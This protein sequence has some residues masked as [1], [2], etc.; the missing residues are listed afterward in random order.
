MNDELRSRHSATEVKSTDIFL[1]LF[2]AIILTTKYQSMAAF[3]N[4][5][6]KEHDLNV[7]LCTLTVV[8]ME[9][10]SVYTTVLYTPRQLAD[11]Q[12]N[13]LQVHGSAHPANHIL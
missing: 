11:A 5:L 12:T 9:G 1:Q 13:R 8:Y 3:S 10:M 7:G 2:I 6:H 4:N